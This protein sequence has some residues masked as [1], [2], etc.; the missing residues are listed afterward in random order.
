MSYRSWVTNSFFGRFS[1]HQMY[2]QNYREE[3]NLLFIRAHIVK[4]NAQFLRK[5]KKATVAYGSST[6]KVEKE[7]KNPNWLS[8]NQYTMS[9]GLIIN[10]S[11]TFYNKLTYSSKTSLLH[12]KPLLQYICFY[13]HIH[14]FYNEPKFDNADWKREANASD[15]LASSDLIFI[16]AFAEAVFTIHS[17]K[18]KEDEPS[19][20][21]KKKNL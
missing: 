12:S 9:T 2:L 3:K 1:P 5:K 13:K 4:N 17:T 16:C 7:K 20:C 19:F 8:Q 10:K 14:T 15:A 11:I 6:Q 21:A 18:K